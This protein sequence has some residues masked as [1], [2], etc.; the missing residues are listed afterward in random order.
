MSV[1]GGRDA[2]R[3][4]IT[5]GITCYDA[6]DT[7]RRAVESAL[8]QTWTAREIIIVDD[9]SADDSATV[10]EEIGR[11]HDEIRLIG[12]GENRG[13]AE[14]RN[15][16]LAEARERLLRS[17]TTMTRARRT[18]SSSSTGESSSTSSVILGSLFSAT[19]TESSFRLAKGSR[20]LSILASA[21]YPPS[22]RAR[23]PRITCLAFSK[24]DASIHGAC[25]GPA[26]SWR[27]PRPFRASRR[28]RW[29]VPPPCRARP[30][31]PRSVRRNP[32]HQRR[33]AVG[34]SVRD[35]DGGQGWRR[36]ASVSPPTRREVSGLPQGKRC[37]AGARCYVHARFPRSRDGRWRLW[38]I[39]AL[40]LFHGECP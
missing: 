34:Y 28:I 38:Y 29:Q 19:P 11:T 35:A 5:I 32:F 39:A 26:R 7:I 14:A 27:E 31:C 30:R 16:V 21:V 1:A 24:D 25:W 9:G 4:L 18:G 22:R 37:Y 17:S 36:P 8:T 13:V 40:I 6:E 2:T 23:S 20:R 3:P 12:H 33:C 10:I 15:T